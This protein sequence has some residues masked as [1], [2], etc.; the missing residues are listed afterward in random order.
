MATVII[1]SVDMGAVALKPH[2]CK[3][4]PVGHC[5]S[6][7]DCYKAIVEANN[8]ASMGFCRTSDTPSQPCTTPG[9]GHNQVGCC[10]PRQQDNG[11]KRPLEGGAPDSA[12]QGSGKSLGAVATRGLATPPD[13]S[14]QSLIAKNPCNYNI[15]EVKTLDVFQVHSD[16]PIL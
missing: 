16:N 6:I 9:N 12:D 10:Q 14:S 8:Q 2:I 5:T 7:N 11:T 13:T 4:V 3:W 15:H 1:F